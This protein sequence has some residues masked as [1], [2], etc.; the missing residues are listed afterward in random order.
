MARKTVFETLG[1][2]MWNRISNSIADYV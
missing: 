2:T 1:E